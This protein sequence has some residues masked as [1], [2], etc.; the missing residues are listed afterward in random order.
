MRA[1]VQ[2]VEEASV[3]VD[4]ETTGSAERGILVYVGVARGDTEG[5]A[6]WM[7]DKAANLRIFQD[8]DGKMNLSVV[9]AGGSA[10]VIS[11]F[12]LLADARKGRRP[13]YSGA[14][15]QGPARELYELFVE[16][17]RR[18][19]GRVETGVFQ[20]EMAVRYTNQG[21]VTILLDSKGAF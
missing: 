1:V 20:A 7:A 4:G 11:Q 19:L 15:E 14:A 9:D 8:A 12:T 21:P 6:A 13:S 17:L 18:K 3:T 2:R 16:A 10:L 5:D